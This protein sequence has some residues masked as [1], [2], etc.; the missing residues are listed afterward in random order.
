MMTVSNS[1]QS[2]A[3][4]PSYKAS[5]SL[6]YPVLNMLSNHSLLIV[7]NKGMV[8]WEADLEKEGDMRDLKANKYQTPVPTSRPM[9]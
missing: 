2:T 5:Y 8:E 4:F 7:N 9:I 1:P 6:D 3:N